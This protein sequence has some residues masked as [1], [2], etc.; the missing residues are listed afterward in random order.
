MEGRL[1]LASLL[2]YISLPYH[3]SGS[4]TANFRKVFHGDNDDNGENGEACGARLCLRR[5]CNLSVV[6]VS[7]QVAPRM[8][9]MRLGIYSGTNPS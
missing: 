4:T 7:L 1:L 9:V 5:F 6:S 3:G 8:G 2:S